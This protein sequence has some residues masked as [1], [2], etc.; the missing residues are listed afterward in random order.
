MTRTPGLLLLGVVLAA[1]GG[2]RAAPEPAAHTAVPPNVVAPTDANPLPNGSGAGIGLAG[3]EV[4]APGNR[5]DP[6]VQVL[7]ESSPVSVSRGLDGFEGRSVS[8]SDAEEL[9]EG[10]TGDER[11]VALGLVWLAREQK[12][13]GGWE[14]DGT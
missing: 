2:A 13:D 5:R 7:Q 11:A 1:V 4:R 8:V 9:V 10:D 12:R 14:Y 3:L 6:F